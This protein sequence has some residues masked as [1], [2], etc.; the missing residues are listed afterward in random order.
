MAK[1]GRVLL[2][3][4]HTFNHVPRARARYNLCYLCGFK[5]CF[6]A[7]AVLVDFFLDSLQDVWV[8]DVLLGCVEVIESDLLYGL[9]KVDRT[10]DQGGC[11]CLE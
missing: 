11:C 4:V 3:V 8:R 2:S 5:E 6:E 7:I 9:N 10:R 1:F